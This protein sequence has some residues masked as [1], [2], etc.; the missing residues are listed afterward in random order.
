LFSHD[1]S[2]L[3]QTGNNTFSVTDTEQSMPCQRANS[4]SPLVFCAL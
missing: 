1:A 4:C 2:F 3:L